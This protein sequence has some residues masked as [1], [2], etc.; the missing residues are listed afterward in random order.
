MNGYYWDQYKDTI[1]ELCSTFKELKLADLPERKGR[2]ELL[3]KLMGTGT[4][5]ALYLLDRLHASMESDGDICEFGVCQGA[6]SALIGNEIKDGVKKLWLFDSFEGLPQPSKEDV[7]IN[8]I[9]NL[10]SMDSYE[11]E[12]C[13]DQ[14]EVRERLAEIA[15]PVERTVITPGF[16][17]DV[18]VSKPMP[19]AVS[20]AYVD[21]DFYTPIKTTLKF[22]HTVLTPGGAVMVDD[23]GFFSAGAQQ[24]VDEFM[25]EFGVDYIFETPMDFAGKF[26][27][28]TRRGH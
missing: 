27:M 12:M 15:F 19:E 22:L 20:F 6:T 3:S 9:F 11:G 23:Y 4:S 13:C 16:I 5:Q 25:E 7:L 17:E 24:A 28:L 26:C 18:I 2:V 14:E 10:G 21:F 8:D 1:S